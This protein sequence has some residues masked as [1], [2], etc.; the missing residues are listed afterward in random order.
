CEDAI[1]HATAG[2]DSLRP[3]LIPLL[4]EAER[5]MRAAL[6][7]PNQGPGSD[8]SLHALIERLRT[9]RP[10]AAA[11]VQPVARPEVTPDT[12]TSP[13]DEDTLPEEEDVAQDIEPTPLLLTGRSSL[14]RRPTINTGI[15]QSNRVAVDLNKVEGL[16]AK[17]TEIVAN[18]TA[19]HGLV[20][21]LGT[22]VNEMVRA[23]QRLQSIA[24]GLQYQITTHGYDMTAEQD[25]DG[26]ALETY[27]PI[28]QLM[29]QLQEAVADQ[30][31]LAQ[32]TMDVVA[33][34]RALAAVETRLDT[35]LQGALL[36]MR[37]LP[38][39]QLRVRLD[40]VVRSAA[41]TAEREVRWTMEGQNVSLDKHVCDRIFEP[42]MHLLRNAIDHGIEPPSEREA[43]G[44][45]RAG[46]I[47]VHAEI[48]GNQAVVTVSDDGRG[49]DPDRIAEVAISRGL[50]GPAQ[51]Q[52]LSS[53]EKLDLI[54]RPGFSTATEVTELSGR[55]MGME[56]VREACTRMGGSVTLMPR[57]G[58]GTTVLLQVPL[59]M[60]LVHSLVVRDAGRLLAIPASQVA[61]V[62]LVPPTAISERKHGHIVRI[63][64]AQMPLFS[65]PGRQAKTSADAREFEERVVLVVPYRGDKA[66]LVVDEI[67]EEDDQIVKPLPHL[68]QG[69]DR[70]L[71]AIVL[72]NGTPT[73][74][75]NLPPLLDLIMQLGEEPAVA[76]AHGASEQV[77]LVV[78]DSL[79]MRTALTQSLEHAGYTVE[80]ARD[81]QEALEHIRNNGLPSLITLDIE[82][83][84][85]DGL[86]AL[87]AIR[88]TPGGE[89]LPIF[90]LT[91]RTGQKH[92]RTAA[93]MGATRYFT[94][95][96]RDSEFIGAVQAATGMA[97]LTG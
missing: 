85:M 44:K 80:T 30:Q 40:Q 6:P 5:E 32:A 58:G 53:R 93:K 51:A 52:Q 12:T 64:A 3:E 87:Y 76:A 67:V 4:F 79:T 69:V 18:R 43:K 61:S 48:E 82:M 33:R 13:E 73:P 1:G 29:L 89:N 97:L 59:S 35:D 54:F 95:P 9:P 38:I 65:L 17:V 26:L 86:E 77:V 25:P 15:N 47:V 72:G 28:R 50:I 37:L 27:G 21:T 57:Q 91:S 71:G 66:A 34:K 39:S 60:S 42:L 94:K 75:L 36:N 78:D 46:R 31:A 92:M 83:P 68:L 55:G 11:I 96:Y 62:H 63:G 2:Q 81:G 88:Q 70:M 7:Q 23:V 16:V 49:V 56:I 22:T 45:P 84:R 14:L 20:E 10:Q 90:I 74:V 24:I 41:A 19:S 8:D